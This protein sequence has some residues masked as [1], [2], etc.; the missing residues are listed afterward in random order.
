MRNAT[1]EQPHGL[2]LLSVAQHLL[3][4][5]P[6]GQHG[7]DALLELGVE[8]FSRSSLAWSA[9]F[10][11]SRSDCRRATSST[12]P[13]NAPAKQPNSPGAP[14][15]PVRARSRLP[16]NAR[17][18]PAAGP[19]AAGRSGSPISHARPAPTPARHRSGHAAD[20]QIIE[21]FRP[22][23][24]RQRN[25][26]QHGE[27]DPGISDHVRQNHVLGV[28]EDQRD[29]CRH[30]SQIEWQRIRNAVTQGDSN[31]EQ[32]GQSFDDWIT[33]RNGIAARAT[34]APQD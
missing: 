34:A 1:G 4:L 21:L 15:S 22:D 24:I 30:K 2:H 31:E 12:M 17:P 28:D 10:R 18:P 26:R 11:R 7:L 27:N 3:V 13:S 33:D 14:E 16:A 6:L 20:R 8:V 5:P 25:P 23:E 19:P 29:E 32:R 9:A